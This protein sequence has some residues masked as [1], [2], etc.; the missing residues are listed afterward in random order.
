[1]GEIFFRMLDFVAVLQTAITNEGSETGGEILKTEKMCRMKLLFNFQSL[2][3]HPRFCK[4]NILLSA[5]CLQ[6]NL[7][8]KIAWN[9]KQK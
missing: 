8:I 4:T 6:T 3:T 9:L 2:R 5:A 1:M 7:G